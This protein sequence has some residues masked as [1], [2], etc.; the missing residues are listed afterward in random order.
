MNNDL[1]AAFNQFFELVHA[2][3]DATVRARLG[4]ISPFI[5]SIFFERRI[6]ELGSLAV[7]ADNAEIYFKDDE[8]HHISSTIEEALPSIKKVAPSV[9]D[10]ITNRGEL[11][12]E[13]A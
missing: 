5:F 2:D 11:L 4:G 7:V 8:L 10:L 3:S 13:A 9:R 12:R 6:G 1:I